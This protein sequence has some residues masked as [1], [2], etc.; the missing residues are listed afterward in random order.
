[1]RT[2]LHTARIVVR[3]NAST[4]TTVECTRDRLADIN[5]SSCG[6]VTYC[7]YG[8]YRPTWFTINR[9]HILPPPWP[10]G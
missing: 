8:L 3:M 2:H 5:M 4:V 9:T 6:V 7:K 10:S 1:M